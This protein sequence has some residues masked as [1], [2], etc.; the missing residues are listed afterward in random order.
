MAAAGDVFEILLH[1]DKFS[2]GLDK[3]AAALQQSFS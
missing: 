3:G 1:Q 2:R